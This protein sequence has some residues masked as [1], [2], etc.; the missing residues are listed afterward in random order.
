MKCKRCTSIMLNCGPIRFQASST[1]YDPIGHVIAYR[2]P[3]CGNYA[4]AQVMRNRQEEVE[5]CLR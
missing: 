4:D 2:C 5:L 1:E 3:C